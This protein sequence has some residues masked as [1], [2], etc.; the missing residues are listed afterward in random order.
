MQMAHRAASSLAER[1]MAGPH[2]CSPTLPTVVH[3]LSAGRESK[4]QLSMGNLSACPITHDLPD[5]PVVAEDGVIYEREAILSWIRS[6]NASPLPITSPTTRRAM[7]ATLVRLAAPYRTALRDMGLSGCACPLT[8]DLPLQPVV[9]EAGFIYDLQ[10]L[11]SWMR[12]CYISSLPFTSP[13]THR[14]MDTTLVVHLAPPYGTALRDMVLSG[15]VSDSIS[16]AWKAHLQLEA[17]ASSGSAAAMW[18]LFLTS[19]RD[20]DMGFCWAEK[21]AEYGHVDAMYS[22]AMQYLQYVVDGDG[23]ESLISKV[24]ELLERAAKQGHKEATEKLT[25]LT[26]DETFAPQIGSSRGPWKLL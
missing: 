19:A 13:M 21:A 14:T 9:A 5:E 24:C 17:K 16:G 23:D 25:L 11:L 4:L 2:L 3:S 26:Q 15:S 10:A 12:N 8:H 18:E 6:C 20:K 1:R 22:V 7:G